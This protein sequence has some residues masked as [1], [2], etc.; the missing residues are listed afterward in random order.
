MSEGRE[1]IEEPIENNKSEQVAVAPVAPTELP[2]EPIDAPVE[3]IE[4]PV[5]PIEAPTIET[6]IETPV[7]PIP[8]E[9]TEAPIEEI[10]EV[11]NPIT[12]EDTIEQPEPTIE[13]NDNKTINI[14][15]SKEDLNRA[16]VAVNGNV[17]ANLVL[18]KSILEKI[19]ENNEDPT[20]I[21]LAIDIVQNIIDPAKELLQLIQINLDIPKDQQLD[22]NTIISKSQGDVDNKFK[23]FNVAESLGFLGLGLALLGGEKKKKHT[24][25]NNKHNKRRRTRSKI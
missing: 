14:P 19:K 21:Q 8:V 2:V 4:A 16:A 7:E 11:E 22:E 1:Q 5:E 17:L 9:P 25:R 20:N 3:P 15:V 24:R 12:Q 13:S 6:S 10:K 23:M 18:Y